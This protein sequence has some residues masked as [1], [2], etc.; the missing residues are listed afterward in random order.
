[1]EQNA[2]RALALADRGYVMRPGE[3][4]AEGPGAELA[5]R[6]DLFATYLGGGVG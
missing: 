4:A 5:A 6:D 2:H 3:I 1:V